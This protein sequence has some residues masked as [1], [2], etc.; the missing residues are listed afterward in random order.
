LAGLPRGGARGSAKDFRWSPGDAEPGGVRREL[1]DR[2]AQG[3]MA[4][5]DS[6]AW[7]PGAW[8][9]SS[10]AGTG[11][12]EPA[13][14]GDQLSGVGA[15]RPPGGVIAVS[16]FCRNGIVV[17]FP[18]CRWTFSIEEIGASLAPTQIWDAAGRVWILVAAPSRPPSRWWPLGVRAVNWA[19]SDGEVIGTTGPYE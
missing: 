1:K 16:F 15:R 13:A 8:R 10:G 17:L 4:G 18:S 9:R 19:C 11:G 5:G 2:S 6:E 14:L 7:W 12:V 3:P